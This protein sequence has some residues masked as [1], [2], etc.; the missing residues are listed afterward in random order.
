MRARFGAMDADGSGVV[1]LGE[2]PGEGPGESVAAADDDDVPAR[3][4]AASRGPCRPAQEVARTTSR[5]QYV[6]ASAEVEFSRGDPDIDTARE[7]RPTACHEV[8]AT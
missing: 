2:G 6:E 3:R 5:C 4:Q 7:K 8:R 1:D